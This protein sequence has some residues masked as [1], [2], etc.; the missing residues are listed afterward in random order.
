VAIPA[1][2][3]GQIKDGVTWIFE[4]DIWIRRKKHFRQ[5][6]KWTTCDLRISD[7]PT[8]DNLTPQETITQ[9]ALDMGPGGVSL[10][11]P[12]SSVVTKVRTIEG[13]EEEILC[14]YRFSLEEVTFP[15]SGQRQALS[16]PS[17]FQHQPVFSLPD[18]LNGG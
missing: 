11:C 16:K 10:S 6:G 9:D 4:F 2:S 7:D 13:F 15:I 17:V 3:R 14:R 18:L 12:G 5:S 1:G 8:S